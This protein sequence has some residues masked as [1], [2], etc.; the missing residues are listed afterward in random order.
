MKVIGITGGV[1][2]GKSTV[3]MML[4]ELC[5]CRI[6]MADDVAKEI[7]AK[8]GALTGQAERLFGAEAYLADGSLNKTHIAY[9]IYADSKLLERWNSIVHPAVN[10]E[11]YRRIDEARQS[12]QYEF[13]FIEAALLIENG[14]DRI[15]DELWYVYADAEVRKE[16]LLKQRGYDYAKT[17][18]II[19]SQLSDEEFRRKCSFVIDTGTEL[20]QVKQIL[21]NRLEVYK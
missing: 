3:I 17:E 19:K 11:I 16:R 10:A 18:S 5:V 7:M 13:T 12:R 15:C 2:A 4:R 1:G 21:Q 8:G 9:M 6:I 14:Y 20:E